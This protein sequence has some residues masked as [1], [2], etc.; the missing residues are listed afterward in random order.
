MKAMNL[1][2]TALAFA[3]TAAS[4][5]GSTLGPGTL[6][7]WAGE[8][9]LKLGWV[10][11][12]PLNPGSTAPLPDWNYSGRYSGGLIP[13]WTYDAT[14]VEDGNPAQWYV[15]MPLSTHLEENPHEFW[16]SYVYERDNVFVGSRAFT[17]VTYD[18]YYPANPSH[19]VFSEEWFDAAGQPTQESFQAVLARITLAFDIPADFPGKLISIGVV[20]DEPSPTGAGFRLL[21]VYHMTWATPE[22]T[23]TVLV[24]AAVCALCLIRR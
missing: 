16:M 13:Q 3:A 14:R 10:F 18:P 20:G 2:A 8:A 6:P 1:F 19:L 12:D 4:S 21:E 11:A 24:F 5:A 22:P 7:S 15:A 9:K 23:T 17:N